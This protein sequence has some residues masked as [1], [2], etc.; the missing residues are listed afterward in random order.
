MTMHQIVTEH[1]RAYCWMQWPMWMCTSAFGLR[2]P[3][4][5]YGR[6]AKPYRGGRYEGAP[7]NEAVKAMYALRHR[8]PLAK[9]S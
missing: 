9:A 6:Q 3:P 4:S 8:H 7:H 2:R 1:A 5:F